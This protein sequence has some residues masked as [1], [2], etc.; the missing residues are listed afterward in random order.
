MV[1]NIYGKTVNKF[2]GRKLLQTWKHRISFSNFAPGV[3]LVKTSMGN[4]NEIIRIIKN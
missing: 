4:S 3:Y 2:T 1:Y